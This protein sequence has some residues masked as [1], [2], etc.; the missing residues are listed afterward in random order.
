MVPA[1]AKLIVPPIR[2][3]ALVCAKPKVMLP[4]LCVPET[5]TVV[6]PPDRARLR[7]PKLSVS[8]VVVVIAVVVA[9]VPS[10]MVRPSAGATVRIVVVVPVAQVPAVVPRPD[11]VLFVSQ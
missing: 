2:V 1:A 11:V 9:K 7:V 5:V 10:I 6:A 8:L 3:M 4:M